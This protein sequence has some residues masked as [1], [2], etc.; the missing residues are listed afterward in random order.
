MTTPLRIAVAGAAGRMGRTLIAEIAG[1]GDLALAG[2][3]EA[4]GSG[5]IGEDAGALAQ[6]APLG[7]AVSDDPLSVIV[8]AQALI[9]F[10]TPA[11]SVALAELTAQ[12]RI[13]HV[14]GTTGFSAADEAKLT[15]AARHATIIRSGNFSLG[16]NVLAGLVRL[17]AKALDPAYDIEIVE[18]HHRAKV[19][20][21]S[22][23]A[24]LLGQ[25]AAEGRGANHLDALRIPARDG[26]T[27]ERVEGS[28]GMAALR[29]GSVVGDHTVILAGP[30]ERIE[31]THRAESRSIFAKGALAAARWGIGKPRGLYSMAD[32]L[33]L[34]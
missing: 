34:A 25:A 29:G 32:V 20:A 10:T 11:T 13:V 23:T 16:V 22:G 24:L 2:A 12:A 9:D 7:L 14:I 26:H 33:G 27:G 19:D 6:L 17:A 21:P 8:Q 1:A 30:N 18:M 4:V 28:I 31:L 3:I 5:A 15:A